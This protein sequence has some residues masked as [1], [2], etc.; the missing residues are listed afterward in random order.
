MKK[1]YAL[2]SVCL[3]F[4]ANQSLAYCQ[5]R[6]V[7]VSVTSL[8]AKRGPRAPPGQINGTNFFRLRILG[9]KRI[10]MLPENIFGRRVLFGGLFEVTS[11]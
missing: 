3:V 5:V 7:I 2:L 9:R 11:A 1:A 6:L 10:L 4:S 8:V